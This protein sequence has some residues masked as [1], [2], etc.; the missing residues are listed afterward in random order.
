MKKQLLCLAFLLLGV[1]GYSQNESE[2]QAVIQPIAA[3]FDAMRAADSATVRAVFHPEARMM[4]T[5]TDESGQPQLRQGTVEAFVQ[6]VGGAQPGMLDEKIWSYD[7]N[8]DGNLATV[9]TDYTFYLNEKMSHCG[10][11]AF[12][13]ASK[14]A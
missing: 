4:T 11:N 14:T 1:F 7:V 12:P 10:V 5:F 9:W 3:L 6:S 13:A 8:I 2:Q